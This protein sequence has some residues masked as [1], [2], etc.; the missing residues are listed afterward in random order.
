[1]ITQIE[2]SFKVSRR[3]PEANAL[4]KIP[5]IFVKSFVAQLISNR[6]QVWKVKL[7]SQ[8]LDDNKIYELIMKPDFK[9]T[10]ACLHLAFN[11]KEEHTTVDWSYVDSSGVLKHDTLSTHVPS[12]VPMAGIASCLLDCAEN[13]RVV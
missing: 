8:Q 9:N 1:M 11:E 4:N 13:K 3:L 6:A 5:N 10:E 7:L 12:I 2:H